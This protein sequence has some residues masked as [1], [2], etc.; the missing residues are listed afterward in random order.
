VAAATSFVDATAAPAAI[1]SDGILRVPLY[2]VSS[3][4]LSETYQ[5]PPIGSSTLKAAVAT[6]DDTVS[7]S[8]LLVGP[9]RYAQKLVL[10]GLAEEARRG[11]AL[12]VVS[13]G[14]L[15]GL[16]LVT[17]M[18]IRVD[19]QVQS[20]TFTETATRRDVIAVSLTLAH[21]PRPGAVGRLLDTAKLA[22]SML[23]APA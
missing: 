22:V 7:L 10:E 1:I 20:L 17:A 6:H 21:V 12:A 4:T 13:G 5:L 23:G 9:G 2:A 16:M 8:G 3:I 19:M 11:S 14:L 18:T 15:T